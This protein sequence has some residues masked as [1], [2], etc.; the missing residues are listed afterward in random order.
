[1]G[2]ISSITGNNKHH[3]SDFED[4]MKG[5]YTNERQVGTVSHLP[6]IL[7]DFNRY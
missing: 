2:I 4:F 3:D 1:M 5:A 7:F 6:F